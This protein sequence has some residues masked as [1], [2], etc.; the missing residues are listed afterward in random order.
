MFISGARRIGD[1]AVVWVSGRIDTGDVDHWINALDVALMLGD[2]PILI[3][4]A[5]VE[6][7]SIAAQAAVIRAGRQAKA[8]GRTVALCRPSEALRAATTLPVF[9]QLA[10]Y[11]DTAVATA[12]RPPLPAP[13]GSIDPPVIHMVGG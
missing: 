11:P 5:A 9:D 12:G 2:G 13:R 3:D 4:V 7:W 10:S 8:R 6:S 1:T